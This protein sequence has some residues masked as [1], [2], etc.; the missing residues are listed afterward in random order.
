MKQR[1]IHK[2]IKKYD[3][4]LQYSPSLDRWYAS[5][6]NDSKGDSWYLWDGKEFK[7]IIYPRHEVPNDLIT[8]KE[9]RIERCLRI[10]LILLKLL[11]RSQ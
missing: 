6:E 10:Y 7:L 4:F 3:Y 2:D 5:S 9:K 8:V 11:S 1:P